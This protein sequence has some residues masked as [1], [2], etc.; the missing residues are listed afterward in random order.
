MNGA[1]TVTV[2]VVLA[3]ATP[4][5]QAQTPSADERAIRE[6]IARYDQQGRQSVQQTDDTIY[7]TGPFKRPTVGAERPDPLPQNEQPSAGASPDRV[8]GSRRRITTPVRI[9]IAASGDL[10]YEFSNSEVVFDLRNGGRESSVPAS[11]L[12]VWKKDAGEWKVAAFFARP[13]YQE[14]VPSSAK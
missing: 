6:L 1:P 14:S 9:E 5:A 3:F 2:A 8:P 7:W 4:V 13:H 10:A 12:R 11:L